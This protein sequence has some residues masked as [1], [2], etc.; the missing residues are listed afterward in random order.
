MFKKQAATEHR[1]RR[2]HSHHLHRRCANITPKYHI[3][4][5]S[6]L[7]LLSL[8]L[9]FTYDEFCLHFIFMKV[10]ADQGRRVITCKLAVSTKDVKKHEKLC[11][12]MQKHMND[13]PA[14]EKEL[15]LKLRDPKQLTT[16]MLK[17]R[18]HSLHT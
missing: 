13:L 7:G 12:V 6:V 15:T 17:S 5:F 14:A 11:G 16:C 10:S 8:Y 3:G 1:S 9:S 2:L 18:V 4:C